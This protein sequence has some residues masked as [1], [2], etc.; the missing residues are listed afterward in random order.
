MSTNL[1]VTKTLLAKLLAGENINVVHKRISTAMFEPKTRTM[2]LP[3]WE[4]MDGEL[5]DLLGGHEVGHALYTPAEGWHSAIHDENGKLLGAFKDVLN[6][7]EDSRIEKLIK[8]KYPGLSRSFVSG[9]K[10]L[11][12]RDFFGVKKLKDYSKLNIL[13]RINLYSKCGSF[14]V[15]PFDDEE[16]E[17]LREVESTETWEDVV[18][19]AMKLFAKAK[20]DRENQMNNLDDLTEELLK[21]FEE[22]MDEDGQSM[23]V[24][25]S[26]DDSEEQDSS[27]E[28]EA[29]AGSD[30][31]ESGEESKEEE[32]E[33]NDSS[34]SGNEESEKEEEKEGEG[35]GESEDDGE[36]STEEPLTGADGAGE[37]GESDPESITDRKFRERERDLIADG[38]EIFT[39]NMPKPMLDRIIVPHRLYIENFYENLVNSQKRAG[40]NDP[41]LAT[42]SKRFGEKNNRYINLLVKEFE[43]RKN[44]RQYA[45]TTVAKTGELDMSKLHT[46]KFSNDLFKKIS[47]VQKGKSHGM[48]MYVDMSG[49]MSD[50]FGSTMEQTLILV[51]FCRKVGIPFD[52]YGFC[53]RAEFL[54]MMISKKKLNAGFIGQKFQK[55]N[56]DTYEISSPGFHL[57]HFISSQLQGASYRRAFDAMAMIAMNWKNKMYPRTYLYWELMG[58]SLGGTPFTHTVMASRPMIE[59]FKLD[60]KVDITNVIY[61]TDGEGTGC[62]TFKDVKPSP[63]TADGK[64]KIKQHIYLIDQKTRRRVEFVADEYGYS[65]PVQH[66]KAMTEFVREVTGCK[67]IGFYIGDTSSIK[68]YIRSNS[69]MDVASEEEMNKQWRKNGYYSMPMIGYDMYYFV[70]ESNLKVSDDDDY[71]ITDGMSSKKIAKVFTDAQDDK[72][73]HRVLVSSFAKDIAA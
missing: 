33:T 26:D 42:V 52:V 54:Q 31:E 3:I 23:E 57:I 20:Q 21:Q 1:S 39:Y 50:V 46:Y 72:R 45:R 67:H 4:D 2:Y 66:Q 44:A 11:F 37:D 27:K 14:I 29:T 32:E 59:K 16:R 68:S 64:A 47:V 7:C 24:D 40:T 69:T 5:Y 41:I 10:N 19:V 35:E 63:R 49:S 8:R 43:M 53:D 6:I 71:N 18:V 13:D 48:I 38:V 28:E 25:L 15:L 9:Y 70:K 62:F 34:G 56:N 61:L 30:S 55:M 58:V 60:N 22:E 36:E 73:R 51:A 12:E 65:V 17:L